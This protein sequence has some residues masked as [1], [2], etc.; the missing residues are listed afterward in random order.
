[1]VVDA[2]A[3]TGKTATCQLMA[4]AAA[5]A[6]RAS[7]RR[8][9]LTYTAFNKAIVEDVRGRMPDNTRVSTIHSIAHSQVVK[10]SPLADRLNTKRLASYE[11]ARR[12]RVDPMMVTIEGHGTKLLKDSYL[13]SYVMRAVEAFCQSADREIGEQHFGVIPGIDW[14]DESGKKTFANNAAVRRAM[15]PKAV[16]AW[17]DL[18][19]PRGQLTYKHSHYLKTFELADPVIPTDVV[20]VD[21]AQDVSPVMNSIFQQQTEAQLVLLGDTNQAIYSFIGAV[22]AME[23]YEADHRRPLT[24]SFRFGPAIAEAANVFLDLLDSPLK[25]V[26]AGPPESS[27]GYVPRPKAILTRTNAEGVLLLFGLLERDIKAAIVG[28]ADDVRR[29]AEAAIQLEEEGATWHPELS[30]FSSWN[31]V[32]S[33][34]ADDPQ[35]SD[36]AAMVKLIEDI[37]KQKV[38]DTLNRQPDVRVC[39]VLLTTTHKAKGL[40][41]DTVRIASDFPNLLEEPDPGKPPISDDEIRLQYVA[42]TRPRLRLDAAALP[43]LAD[44]LSIDA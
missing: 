8:R 39:E 41:F 32:I 1:M 12:L 11:I 25:V 5:V 22:D 26:G 10:G 35:G 34:V 4:E 15:L 42:V 29:F 3:G 21:E 9:S 40:T 36:L 19:S 2:L 17:E 38:V 13:A 33:Y 30:C 18:T 43:I 24:A 44:Q 7:G 16:Q 27:V 28:G 37:G 31:E 23:S 14:P 20:I 6:D